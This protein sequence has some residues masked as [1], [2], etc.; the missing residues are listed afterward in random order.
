MVQC[1]GGMIFGEPEILRQIFVIAKK[2]NLLFIADECAVGFYR[3]G[4][5]FGFHH[6]EISPDIIA[7]GKALTGG[8]LTLAATLVREEIFE[9]F[10]GN[11]LNLALMHGPTFMGNP[12]ACAAANASLD[13]FEQINYEQKVLE[14][15]KF[16]KKELEKCRNLKNVK[17]VRTLGAIGVVELEDNQETGFK[18]M[19]ELRQTFVKNGVFLRPFANCIYAMPALNIKKVGLKKITDAICNR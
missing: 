16:F 1:A 10:L 2:Y 14:I 6:A 5:K 13:L 8:T 7:L 19:L 18:K 3:T 4:K 12:L 15:E 11:S 9:K 17:D